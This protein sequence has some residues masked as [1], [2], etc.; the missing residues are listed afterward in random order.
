MHP[1]A[2]RAAAGFQRER[3]RER[4]G[5]SE[6]KKKRHRGEFPGVA[7]GH[8]L[9]RERTH[10]AG[11]RGSSRRAAQDA[12][13][14]SQRQREQSRAPESPRRERPCFPLRSD[15]QAG[16]RPLQAHL[17]FEET[18]QESGAAPGEAAWLA[19]SHAQRKELPRARRNEDVPG[20]ARTRRACLAAVLGGAR[21][22][23]ARDTCH[24]PKSSTRA[25]G[26]APSTDA[27]KVGS[28]AWPRQPPP[29]RKVSVGDTFFG[30]FLWMWQDCFRN[31]TV[32]FRHVAARSFVEFA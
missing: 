28:T 2:C 25:Q 6:K 31:L 18:A 20:S 23:S 1:H 14:L 19:E 21:G 26:P 9:S 32:C 29:P 15:L 10:C 7:E 5:G 17:R 13:A 8:E 27:C 16:F 22:M 24:K 4:R 30:Y 12:C 11:R 3:T